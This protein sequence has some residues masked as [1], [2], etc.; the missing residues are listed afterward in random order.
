MNPGCLRLHEAAKDFGDRVVIAPSGPRSSCSH[1]VTTHQEITIRNVSRNRFAIEGTPAD[2]VRLGLHHLAPEATWVLAGINAGGNLG[3]DI[4]H[5]G[6]VAAAREAV[7]HGRPAI[8]FSHYIAR[9]RAI[10]WPRATNWAVRALRALLDLPWES[11][12][13][14]NVN[15][16]HPAPDAVEP[17]I[18]MCPVDSSPLPLC[19][20]VDPDGAKA[21]YN[22]DYQRRDRVPSG[23]VDVCFRGN[24]AVSRVRLLPADPRPPIGLV[25]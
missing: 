8:A 17:M 21:T 2:C 25:E 22:G 1:A 24:I 19:F 7:L 13:F 23:D 3:A 12:T 5:S 14:W 11:G 18:V 15:F 10:D 16:P 6:T 9:D 20:R 4:H